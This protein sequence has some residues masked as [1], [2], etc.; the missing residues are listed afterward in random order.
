MTTAATGQLQVKLVWEQGRIGALQCNLKRPLESV[1]Q[2]LVKQPAAQACQLLP[3]LFSVCGHSHLL[4]GQLASGLIRVHHPDEQAQLHSLLRQVWRENLRESLIRLCRDWGYPLGTSALQSALRQL[5][6][7]AE[8]PNRADARN[9]VD[10]S[11]EPVPH[12]L[13][14]DEQWLA[15]LEQQWLP[16]EGLVIPTST[17]DTCCFAPDYRLLGAGDKHPLLYAGMGAAALL[18]GRG[19]P[20][21]TV[22]A[23]IAHRLLEQCRQWW[24]WSQQDMPDLASGL[25]LRSYYEDLAMV[26]KGWV[27]TSRGWLLHQVSGPESRRDWL[28]QAP[29]D[30]N[31]GGELLATLLVGMAVADATQAEEVCRWLVRAIDPCLDCQIECLDLTAGRDDPAQPESNH[32][33]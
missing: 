32:R 25:A 13:C 11:G 14:L 10:N 18:Y 33:A 21:L 30:V 20:L 29:T 26:R 12:W 28:I 22:L 31:F 4:A 2:L 6:Q 3:M 23:R 15:S 27:H 19:Q 9:P 16:L 17:V 1:G 24:Q 5:A 7:L 8:K